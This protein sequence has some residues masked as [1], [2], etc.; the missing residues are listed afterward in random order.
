[1]PEPKRYALAIVNGHDGPPCRVST[2]HSIEVTGA[3]LE[4]AIG[5]EHM[6]TTVGIV[7]GSGMHKLWVPPGLIRVRRIAGSS[8][9]SVFGWG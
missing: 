6:G 4:D 1:M 9:I 7:R 5:I 8:K 3:E 2:L